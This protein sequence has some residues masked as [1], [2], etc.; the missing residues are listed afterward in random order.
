MSPG[1][2]D[3]DWL[4]FRTGAVSRLGSGLSEAKER[5][6]FSTLCQFINDH[7]LSHEPLR[8]AS[9]QDW[10]GFEVR[11]SQLTNLGQLVMKSGLSRWLGAIDRGTPPAKSKI[12]LRTLEKVRGASAS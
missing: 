8:V 10:D 4:L 3:H 9:D 12:L 2:Q 6:V 7:G 5:A 11:Y 1:Q